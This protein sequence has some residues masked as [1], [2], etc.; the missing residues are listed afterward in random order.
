MVRTRQF[1]CDR[2]LGLSWLDLSTIE[3]LL[4]KL[5]R[6]IR[7]MLPHSVNH[8]QLLQALQ[9]EWDKIPKMSFHCNAVL[10]QNM[11]ILRSC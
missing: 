2:D 3:Q 6:R 9:G 8:Q 11:R 5:D 7:G 1:V 4:D 10:Q